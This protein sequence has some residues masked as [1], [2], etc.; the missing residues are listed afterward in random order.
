MGI[1]NLLDGA[2]DSGGG[3]GVE[4]RAGSLIV[5]VTFSGSVLTEPFRN[6]APPPQGD[7]ELLN[8]R[9]SKRRTPIPA[10]A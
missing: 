2:A 10:E 4:D 6:T 7:R 5:T 3:G 1:S 8:A 9:R